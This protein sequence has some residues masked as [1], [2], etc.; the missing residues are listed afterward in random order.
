MVAWGLL[1][2]SVVCTAAEAARKVAAGEPITHGKV[3]GTLSEV[4]GNF[5]LNNLSGFATNA[6]GN[7][8]EG[9]ASVLRNGDFERVTATAIGHAIT[10]VEPPSGSTCCQRWKWR[11]A[12]GRLVAAAAKT[13][14][15]FNQHGAKHLADLTQA[16]DLPS[17]LTSA[18]LLDGNVRSAVEASW[19][20]FLVCA[21]GRHIVPVPGDLLAL[22][23]SR[24]HE[25][26][27]SLVYH[28][29]REDQ[30]AANG[31]LILNTTRLLIGQA[32]LS[33]QVSEVHEAVRDVPRE[34]VRLLDERAAPVFA[35]VRALE[36][37]P[38]HF[39][40]R[41]EEIARL[42]AALQRGAGAAI[43]GQPQAVHGAGGIGKSVLARVVAHRWRE[44]HPGRSAVE[45]DLQGADDQAAPVAPATALAQLI[46]HFVPKAGQLPEEAATLRGLYL[47]QLAKA[48]PLVLLDNAR[49]LAQIEPLLP[50]AGC[51]LIV[52]S[53]QFLEIPGAA[54][55][56]LEELPEE[57]AREL[58]LALDSALA[59]VAGELV[60]LC[61]RHPLALELA[62]SARR[63]HPL[64][65]PE[66]LLA[67]LRATR[68]EIHDAVEAA[69]A[70]SLGL[71]DEPL[72]QQWRKL[73]IFPAGFATDA[74][75]AIWGLEIPATEALLEQLWRSSLVEIDEKTR[76]SRLHDRARTVALARLEAGSESSTTPLRLAHARHYLT[77]LAKCEGLFLTGKD[78]A[79]LGL[80]LFE[81]ERPHIES[82]HDWLLRHLIPERDE[83]LVAYPHTG[84][85]VLGLRQHPRERILWLAASAEAASRSGD[86]QAEGTSLGN[87]G[88]AWADLGENRRSI[89]FLEQH[90]AIAR[91][92]G[93]RHGEADALGNLG[94]AW[95]ALGEKRKAIDF[96]NQHLAI[97]REF[98]DRRG[99][100]TCLGNL[101]NA[102]ASHGEMRKAID[103]HNQHLAIARESGDRR[104]EGTSL[105]NLGNAWASLGE[106]RKAIDFHD[107]HLTIA[108]EIG[109]RRGE[110]AAICNLGN[111]WVALGETRKA[112][113]FHEQHLA[114]AREIADR[115]GEGTAL[116]NLGLAWQAIGEKRRALALFDQHLSIAREIGD[117]RGEGYAL[118]NL[119]NSWLQLVEKHKAI[120]FFQQ[121]LV[122]TRAIGDRRGEGASLCGLGNA[123]ASLGE[124]RRAIDFY[125]Q[126]LAVSRETGDVD[127]EAMTL[128]NL[129]KMCRSSGEL[130]RAVGLAKEALAIFERIESPNAEKVRATLAKWA[131]ED[132]AGAT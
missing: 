28:G 54:C 104:G 22:A 82:A 113:D 24:L 67:G 52:T 58:L 57:K 94:S 60:T 3:L 1:I 127:M 61:G 72:R 85:H 128:I 48:R 71:L 119:G 74:G 32:A 59:P 39:T 90:L 45:I 79:L 120:E 92:I 96:H 6:V 64:L 105:G 41:D 23:A 84:I 116:G 95:A 131:T 9:A 117:R 70:F 33:D 62:G 97:A 66:A 4:L 124:N 29:V 129:A 80:A 100:G 111:A 46:R 43:A 42:L 2:F 78:Q 73:G 112:I 49:D 83:L 63:G 89:D 103:F 114:I 5:G 20:T 17:Q 11:R 36:A 81:I 126:S 44:E 13:W 91:E 101:G 93:D 69:F 25:H 10:L 16:R 77:V 125:E 107:Q 53:R 30:S 7:L 115:H 121:A 102:W 31:I 106:I 12:R 38:A 56:H 88:N 34:V 110:G 118:V 8:G 75:A 122:I 68:H 65:T 108:R 130:E 132:D 15:V 87:L 86:R 27:P 21:A 51:P 19:R 18:V 26:L 50:P 99:E 14:P 47:D 76:R 123:T 40:G 109:D 55:C 37:P 35:E 98:G